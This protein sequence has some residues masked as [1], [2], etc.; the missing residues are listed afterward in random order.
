MP[1]T[2]L[3]VSTIALTGTVRA[4]TAA[5]AGADGDEFENDGKTLYE[6]INAGVG[7]TVVTFAAT[8]A[9][10]QA[11]VHSTSTSVAAGETKTFG[12][13]ST[14]RFNNTSGRVKVTYSVVTSV[15]VNASRLPS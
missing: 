9:C 2:V 13:F 1:A 8:G 12:P 6:V 14:S 15:T 10:N 5:T 3:T 7:A 4:F 11:V